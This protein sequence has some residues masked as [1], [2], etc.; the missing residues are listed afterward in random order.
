MYSLLI[1]QIFLWK[2]IN[3]IFIALDS[4]LEQVALVASIKNTVY[5]VARS[6]SQDTSHTKNQ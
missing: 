3:F 2:A 6:H 4:K 5:Y 1:I